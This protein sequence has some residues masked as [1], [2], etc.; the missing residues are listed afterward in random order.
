M[1]P[2]FFGY[3]DLALLFLRVVLAVIFIVH[4]WSKVNNLKKNT[5]AFNAMGFK[6]GSF[7]G[8]I[9]ALLEFFGGIAF[10]FGIFTGWLAFLFAGEFLVILI[11]R[12]AKNH[13]FVSGWEFDLL[14]F[15]ALLLFVSIGAGH[16]VF[17]RVLFMGY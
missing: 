2:F 3:G 17:D 5:E 12:L 11:W 13:R 14:I 16:F 1:Y 6:P 10:F 8:T 15:A 4:G 9:A 7:W